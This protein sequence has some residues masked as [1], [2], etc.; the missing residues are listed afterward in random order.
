MEG[1]EKARQF[2]YRNARPLELARWQY[3]FENG[4]SA[5]VLK[6]LQVY[7]NEDGGFG[8]GLEPDFWNPTSSPIATWTACNILREI[9]SLTRDNQLTQGILNYLAS[10]Q[11][12][13]DGKWFNQVA[14]TKDY[15]H[16]VWWASDH[17]TPADN[18]TVSLAGV[19]I[20]VE[21]RG[22]ALYQKAQGIIQQA[23]DDF[24][25]EPT[26]EMHTL[27]VYLE[28][29]QYCEEAQYQPVLQNQEFR[30]LLIQQIQKTVSR[31]TE[32]WFS[33]YVSKPSDFFSSSEQLLTIFDQDL[34]SQEATK[35]IENQLEDGSFNV[36]WQWGNDYVE[37]YISRNWW[38]AIQ[39]IK[40]FLF[41]REFVRIEDET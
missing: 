36:P 1:F 7:Q 13:A 31:T 25:K 40:N 28:M 21:E 10:G 16:A 3:H 22:T 5:D 35:I 32:E 18:P 27:V 39:L 9:D 4:N 19:I 20:K 34:C 11:D 41:L 2:M 33:K 38:K 8:H 23:M 15:P 14:S 26:S 29:L 30:Q 6:V 37:F 17:G 12:F 24:I